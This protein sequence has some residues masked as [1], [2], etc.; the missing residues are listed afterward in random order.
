MRLEHTTIDAT[1][2]SV[3]TPI[4]RGYSNLIPSVSIQRKLKNSSLTFGYTQRIQRPGI[5]QL[6]PFINQSNPNFITTGNPDLKPEL[7]NT[8]EFNYSNFAKSPVTIG[9]SYAFSGNSIQNVS[10][11]SIQTVNNKLD[12][13]TTTTYQ[14]LGSNK[15]L[16]LNANLNLTF[17]KK[18]S[19]NAN[20]HASYVWLKGTYNSNTY[21]NSGY[22]SNTDASAAYKFDNGFRIGFN[23]G[24]YVPNVTLQGKNGNY[25][26][27]AYVLS[28]DFLDKKATISFI[29]NNPYSKYTTQTSYVSTSDFYQTSYNTERYATFAARIN[30]RFGKLNSEIKK[31]KRGITE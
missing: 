13:I 1:F 14:N 30:Y 26:Y 9:V 22:G 20:A 18:L 31:N 2:S 19:I 15:T 7:S 29:A 27:N 24:Y 21:A 5:W 17:F 23:F 28:K 6:N 16:G 10:N 25:L 3:G 4:D 11:I 12:T 8:F